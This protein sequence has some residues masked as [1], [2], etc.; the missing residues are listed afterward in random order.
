[1]FIFNHDCTYLYAL[2]YIDD[3]L[4]TRNKPSA[5]QFF[6]SKLGTEFSLRDLGNAQYFLGIEVHKNEHGILLNQQRYI[7]D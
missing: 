6:I 3:I 7:A 1:M 2:I 4:I 5:V